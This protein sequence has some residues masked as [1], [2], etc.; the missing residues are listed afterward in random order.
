M[1]LDEG[2]HREIL[3]E[4]L[5]RGCQTFVIGN[6]ATRCRLDFVQAGVREFREL[7][8]EAGVA[9]VDATHYGTEKP[10]QL[11]MLDWFRRLGLSAEF[12]PDGP[13]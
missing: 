5:A 8:D 2:A 1:R 12:R 7:A 3:E 6:A 11:A 4:S 13:K 9:V 10:P